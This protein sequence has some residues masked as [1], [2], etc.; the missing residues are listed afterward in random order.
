VN[1]RALLNGSK[2]SVAYGQALDGALTTLC[3][4][5]RISSG[6]LTIFTAIRR[7]SGRMYAERGP[8]RQNESESC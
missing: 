4:G 5:L 7:A 1:S 2:K 6:S 3:E 8:N